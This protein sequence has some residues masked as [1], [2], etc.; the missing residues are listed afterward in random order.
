MVTYKTSLPKKN[1]PT[2]ARIK[3]QNPNARRSLE[4]NLSTSQS[5]GP[6][7]NLDVGE[8]PD[9]E[10]DRAASASTTNHNGLR[11]TAA[12]PSASS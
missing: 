4:S 6:Y 8:N 10:G 5:G 1:A 9:H 12:Y 11:F 3:V 7:R 2:A